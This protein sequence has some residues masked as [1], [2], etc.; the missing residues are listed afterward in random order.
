M[1]N[2]TNVLLIAVLAVIVAFGAYS[3]HEHEKNT[4]TMHIG[5]ATLSLTKTP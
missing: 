2:Q 3:Y 5:D 4:A 1:N